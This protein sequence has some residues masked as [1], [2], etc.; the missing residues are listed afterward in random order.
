MKLWLALGFNGGLGA[1]IWG[2]VVLAAAC[3]ACAVGTGIAAL[4]FFGAAGAV[5]IG[6]DQPDQLL[7]VAPGRGL[8][9]RLGY[10]Q[11]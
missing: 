4:F 5:L 3:P 8:S 9:H 1:A 6:D 2:T 10:I 11:E 7:Y